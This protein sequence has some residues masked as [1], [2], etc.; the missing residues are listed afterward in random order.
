MFDFCVVTINDEHTKL[1]SK[2]SVGVKHKDDICADLHLKL[3]FESDWY[4]SNITES[5]GF[6][7]D[8]PEKKSQTVTF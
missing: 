6:E 7:S 5:E 3:C 8:C 4:F 2:G 1:G